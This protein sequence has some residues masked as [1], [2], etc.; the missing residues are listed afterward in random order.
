MTLVY[1]HPRKKNHFLNV[2]ICNLQL[3]LTEMKASNITFAA[4]LEDVK[5]IQAFKLVHVA[6]NYNFSIDLNHAD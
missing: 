5:G 1:T 3:M 6:L 4:I 2:W